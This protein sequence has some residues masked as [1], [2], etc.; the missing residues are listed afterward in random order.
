MFDVQY[1]SLD[2][3]LPQNGARTNVARGSLP[4]YEVPDSQLNTT[5]IYETTDLP[6]ANS[7]SYN[8]RVEGNQRTHNDD[9]STSLELNHGSARHLKSQSTNA[10]LSSGIYQY[11][12]A[13]PAVNCKDNFGYVKQSNE[14][15]YYYSLEEDKSNDNI[16]D[17]VTDEK[18]EHVYNVLEEPK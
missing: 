4:F 14:D 3:T 2:N 10:S 18:Q 15:P 5:H 6:V 7:T 12:D 9:V 8:E 16:Y 13:R 17:R 1:Y 11:I